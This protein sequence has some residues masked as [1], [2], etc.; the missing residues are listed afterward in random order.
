MVQSRLSELSAGPL[1]IDQDG[2]WVALT[3]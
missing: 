3:I 2:E 1:E